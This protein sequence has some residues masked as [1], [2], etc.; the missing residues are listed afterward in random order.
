MA[1]YGEDGAV[2]AVLRAAEAAA[3]GDLAQ[4]DHW[5]A[6]AAWFDA[7]DGPVH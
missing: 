6:V 3:L 2:V 1:R 5:Q 7:P 4:S